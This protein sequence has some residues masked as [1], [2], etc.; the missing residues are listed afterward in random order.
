MPQKKKKYLQSKY[1]GGKISEPQYLVEIIC[2]LKA[3]HNGEYLSDKFWQIDKWKKEFRKQI[4]I[5]NKLLKEY[6]FPV[7][8]NAILHKD[9]ITKINSLGANWL[10]KPILE[11][12]LR[13]YNLNKSN[14]QATKADHDITSK[15]QKPLGKKTLLSKLG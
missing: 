4:T 11:E 3:K 2:D 7:I 14:L 8:M 12:E 1:G 15:P 5:A 6:P 9:C 10:L 13:K